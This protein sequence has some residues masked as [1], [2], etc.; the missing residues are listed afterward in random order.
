MITF[1]EA[2]IGAIGG[3]GIM[4]KFY[5]SNIS[6]SIKPCFAYEV[7]KRNR[8]VLGVV[9]SSAFIADSKPEGKS[10]PFAR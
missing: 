10:C 5:K 6:E 7:T 3:G 9:G 4:K 2:S 8:N 1:S